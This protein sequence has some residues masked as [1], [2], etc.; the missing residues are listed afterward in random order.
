MQK[1]DMKTDD[2]S[3]VVRNAGPFIALL[4]ALLS[5]LILRLLF[6]EHFILKKK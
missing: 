1:I 4:I 6:F 3:G 2:V 5:K